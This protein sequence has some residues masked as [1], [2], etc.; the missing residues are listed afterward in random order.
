MILSIAYIV[1]LIL[2]FNE[3]IILN[4]MDQV[5]NKTHQMNFYLVIDEC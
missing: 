5:S 4:F 3:H 2:H 1:H